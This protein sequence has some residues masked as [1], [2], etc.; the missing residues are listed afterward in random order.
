MTVFNKL[1]RFVRT[2]GAQ[3]VYSVCIPRLHC[4]KRVWLAMGVRDVPYQRQGDIQT[5]LSLK[6]TTNLIGS[7]G[8]WVV[9][10]EERGV[11]KHNNKPVTP[12]P[13]SAAQSENQTNA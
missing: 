2:N 10:A 11:E 12:S 3:G 1:I 7:Q 4:G 9:Y 5:T 13:P 6:G 8:C